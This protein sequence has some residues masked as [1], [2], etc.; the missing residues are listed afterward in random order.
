MKI[1]LLAGVM[2]T[3]P[4][5]VVAIFFFGR[6]MM[7]PALFSLAIN[8]LPFIVAGLLLRDKTDAMTH[9]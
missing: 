3:L 6:S 7:I 8:L 4:A 2:I 9:H 1:M 5:I